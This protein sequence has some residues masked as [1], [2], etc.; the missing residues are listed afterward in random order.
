MPNM[1]KT[2][3]PVN[4]DQWKAWALEQVEGMRDLLDTIESDIHVVESS[5]NISSPDFP[6]TAYPG[7]QKAEVDLDTGDWTELELYGH[8]DIL[9][10]WA[11][12]LDRVE[13]SYIVRAERIASGITNE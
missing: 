4:L 9:R 2:K 13:R 11:G 3:P 8:R 10:H 6:T 12:M 7:G 5:E 1:K